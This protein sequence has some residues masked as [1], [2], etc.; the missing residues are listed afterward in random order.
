MD[1]TNCDEVKVEVTYVNNKTNGKGNVNLSLKHR[2][3]NNI[4][5]KNRMFR[6][7]V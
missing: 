2:I 1:V 7:R 3:N 6:L 5:K 4:L